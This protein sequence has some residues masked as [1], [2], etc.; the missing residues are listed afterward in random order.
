[1]NSPLSS[2]LLLLFYS[3]TLSSS[4]KLMNTWQWLQRSQRNSRSL[5]LIQQI[6][7]QKFPSSPLFPLCS[8]SCLCK[9]LTVKA[10]CLDSLASA[11]FTWA[12]LLVSSF[13]WK[14]RDTRSL[15]CCL[16]LPPCWPTRPYQSDVNT[17]S[18]ETKLWPTCRRNTRTKHLNATSIYMHI[19][20]YAQ[21][22]SM[23]ALMGT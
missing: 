20:I 5:C 4:L 17:H 7:S 11:F 16:S 19:C 12:V 18:A 13:G 15:L 23:L 8:K 9:I 2:T 10:L 21:L 14:S 1:M 3:S 6:F 22:Y